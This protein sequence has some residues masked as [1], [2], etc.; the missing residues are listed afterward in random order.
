MEKRAD[1]GACALENGTA[2]AALRTRGG[3]DRQ[4]DTQP[5]L[6]RRFRRTGKE[7]P[8]HRFHGADRFGLADR[9]RH[10]GLRPALRPHAQSQA[11]TVLGHLARQAAQRR[12]GCRAVPV[13]AGLRRPARP[14]R[15]RGK[16][17]GGAHGT[18]PERPGDQSFRTAEAG[19]R[20]QCGGTAPA[21]APEW[22]TPDPGA[23]LSHRYPRALA[24]LLAG[25]HRS[26]SAARRAQRGG[27]TGADGRPSP[28]R[29]HRRVLRRRTWAPWPWTRA[30]ASPSPPA[31]R[32]GRTTRKRSSALPAPSSTPT[33][34]PP[35][36]WSWRSSTPAASSNRTPRTAW[37]PRN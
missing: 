25:E 36:R 14:R 19:W 26:A 7:R 6:G 3:D 18:V 27:S 15:Q 10:P 16:R 24:E 31:R 33:R 35:A 1:D 37:A 23:D 34:T 9:G 21:S 29:A 11:P 17:D 2:R 8:G 5:G 22:C 30:R 12:A 4:S 28:G 32:S 20:D 13:R